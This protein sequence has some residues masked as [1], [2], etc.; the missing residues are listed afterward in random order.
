[1]ESI[2]GAVISRVGAASCTAES[3]TSMRGRAGSVVAIESVPA[4]A[5]PVRPISNVSSG[6]RG[7]GSGGC[8][9]IQAS[10]PSRCP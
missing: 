9:T 1:M 3:G 10:P 6:A 5:P 7:A 2:D 8:R 4:A